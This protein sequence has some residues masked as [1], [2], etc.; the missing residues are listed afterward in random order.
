[1]F[2]LLLLGYAAIASAVSFLIC[3]F[4]TRY[5]ISYLFKKKRTVDDYHKP[6][7]PQVPRPG[8][9]AIIAAI[10]LSEIVLFAFTGSYAVLGLALVTLLSG[11]V[12]IV[13][14]LKTLGG[15]VK[16]A[17]LLTGGL[18][19]IALQFLFPGAMVY[20]H[21]LYLPLFHVPTSIP[22]IYILLILVAIPV[23]TNTINTIDVLN[24]VVSGTILIASFPVGFAIILRI[25][26]GKENPVILASLFPIIAATL[27]FYLFHRYPSK[28]FPGDSGAMALGAAYGTMAIIG[29]VEVVAVIA[30]LP[31]IMNSF[32][33]LSS[34]KRLVEHREIKAQ[35]TTVLP[36]SRMI[37]TAEAKA[38]ITLTRLLVGT[39]AKG[40]P[41]IVHDIFVLSW[42]SAFL[43][44]LTAIMTWVI[45][46]A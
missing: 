20:D 34:M 28:I 18:P 36:D 29:G 15:V 2:G 23:V 32:F 42:F 46:F 37:A 35:P 33:F 43:A 6:G 10:V 7:R 31:A 5:L 26:S 1:L 21:H 38:P 16:P 39:K 14:D 12:G 11:I 41:E 24:G 40:E 3:F 4:G 19:L 44:C 27:A 13:D 25:L 17:L 8:G 45:T 30:I 22:I 9:P